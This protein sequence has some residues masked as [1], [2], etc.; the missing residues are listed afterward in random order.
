MRSAKRRLWVGWTQP[1]PTTMPATPKMF[2]IMHNA[3]ARLSMPAERPAGSGVGFMLARLVDKVAPEGYEDE[4]GF[5]AMDPA[6]TNGRRLTA[7]PNY[8][9]EHI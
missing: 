1:N 2:G 8:R 7:E 9:G 4:A 6:H 5:H 3:A